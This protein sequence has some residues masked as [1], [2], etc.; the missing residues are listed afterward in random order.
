M[1]GNDKYYT[2]DKSEYSD[3]VRFA[4]K[5]IYQNKVIVWVTISDRISKPS[6]RPSKSEAVH[7]NIYINEYLE[8]RLLPFIREHHPYSNFIFWPDLGGCHYSKQAVA[9]MDENV[10]FV[11]K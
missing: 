9:W 4:G 8:K 1:Q 2:K 6:F 11:P 10:K 3:N 5:E 7:L